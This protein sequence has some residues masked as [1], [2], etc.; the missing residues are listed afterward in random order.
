MSCPQRLSTDAAARRVV[1]VIIALAIVVAWPASGGYGAGG[2][3]LAPSS[4]GVARGVVTVPEEP[5]S[6]VERLL[7]GLQRELGSDFP[8]VNVRDIVRM[9]RGDGGALDFRGLGGAL[10]AYFA[11]EL[12]ANARLLGTLLALVVL[13]GVLLALRSSFGDESVASIAYLVGCVVLASLAITGLRIAIEAARDHVNLTVDF[14]RALLPVLLSLLIGVGAVVTAGL[15][16]PWL[17][18]S[19]YAIATLASGVVIPLMMVSAACE[20]VSSLG[21]RIRVTG[22][23]ALLRQVCVTLLGLSMALF[24]GVMTI[25]SAA[26]SVADGV[27]LRTGKFLASSFIPVIGKMFGDAMEMVIGG[28]LVLKNAVGIAGGVAVFAMTALPAMKIGALILV[29]RVASALAQ[30]VADRQVL[31]CLD[32]IASC[33]TIVLLAVCGVGLAWFVSVV[34]LMGAG[35]AAVMLR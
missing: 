29:Y 5:L 17:L 1:S 28:S 35:N 3:A 25:Q 14:M 2:E 6:E 15:F 16:S 23:A 34:M 10:A 12:V 33:L 27:A 22:V 21:A 4:E 32:G 13:L 20:V 26:G 30:P 7:L 9:L 19:T 24:L 11:R 31:A 8:S 18:F